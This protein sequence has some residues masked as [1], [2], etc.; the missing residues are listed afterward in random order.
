LHRIKVKISVVYIFSS[1]KLTKSLLTIKTPRAYN[2]LSPATNGPLV[3][4]FPAFYSTN[5]ATVTLTVTLHSSLPSAKEPCHTF[6]L[7][8]LQLISKSS[9]Y[10]SIFNL[11][12]FFISNLY[13]W[14]GHVAWMGEGRGVYRVLVGKPEGK[15]PLGRTRHR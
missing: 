11:Y 9:S 6:H 10:L 13:V 14:A 12:V 7:T 15:R 3:K 1:F 8:S 2:L 5:R 4:Q